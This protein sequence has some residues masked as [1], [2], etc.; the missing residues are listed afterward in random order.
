MGTFTRCFLCHRGLFVRLQ[1]HLGPKRICPSVIRPLSVRSSLILW[2]RAM[3]EPCLRTHDLEGSGA[4]IE[5]R[6]VEIAIAICAMPIPGYT[7]L[8]WFHLL[9]LL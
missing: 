5:I 9:R 8:R 4:I 1:S 6:E 7:G 2:E 3:V